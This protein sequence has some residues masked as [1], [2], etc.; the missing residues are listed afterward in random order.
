MPR[1]CSTC[2]NPISEK[3]LVALPHCTQCFECKMSSDEPIMAAPAS[4]LAR[5][6]FTQGTADSPGR[7]WNLRVYTYGLG[8]AI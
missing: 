6:G 5:L 7:S 3:R 2:P 4:N 1:Q 8:A